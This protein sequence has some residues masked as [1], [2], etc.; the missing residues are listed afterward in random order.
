MRKDVGVLLAGVGTGLGATGA[1]IAF[2]RQYPLQGKTVLI[3]GGSR[4]L[5]LA[6]AREFASHGARLAI[7]ARDQVEL[8]LARQDL[9]ARGGEVMAVPRDVSIREDAESLAREVTDRFGSV[10]V[11]VNNAGVVE[12]GPMESMALDDFEEAMRVHFYGPLYLTLAVV[13]EMRRRRDGRIVNISSIGGL[14]SVPHLLPYCA[15]KFALTGFSEG[16]RA[17]LARDNVYVTTV[18]PG[19]MRTGS[20]RH[21][22]FKGHPLAE[23]RWFRASSVLPLLT[24]HPDRAAK[25]IVAACRRG[26]AELILTPQAKALAKAKAL[27]PGMV[28]GLMQAGHRVL[29]DAYG[30]T[31]EKIEGVDLEPPRGGTLFDRLSRFAALRLNEYAR[32]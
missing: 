15:S 7:C 22:W 9:E 19:L 26:A 3:T 25:K 16:L 10:D 14:V 11:L 24:M 8:D 13:P 17:E 30:A 6:L 2:R 20:T 32:S 1:L 18:A 28:I 21:A 12:V 29:P 27:F 5:G 23:F 31:Q 4:G